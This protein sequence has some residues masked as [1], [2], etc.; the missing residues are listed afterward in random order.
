[1]AVK[2]GNKIRYKGVYRLY[3]N[4]VLASETPYNLTDAFGSTPA[5]TVEELQLMTAQD[6]EARAAAM[7]QAISGK[8]NDF[9]VINN[10]IY[11]SDD[12]SDEE[13]FMIGQIIDFAGIEGTWDTDKWLDCDGRTLNTADYPELY[14]VI[15]REW[16]DASLSNDKFQLP[17]LGGRIALG[18]DRSSAELPRNSTD[19]TAIDYNYGRVGNKGGFASVRLATRNMPK[20]NHELNIYNV[21]AEHGD[22]GHDYYPAQ[23]IQIAAPAG[24][25]KSWTGETKYEGGENAQSAI[26]HENRQPYAV[27]R[28]LIRYK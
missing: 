18:F 4:G 15:G 16:T 22:S 28:K 7:I 8:C 19:E 20:H 2:T 12:C 17:Y 26:R 13:E 21:N 10:V 1:M 9:E 14:G 24:T 3:R 5:I 25:D 23:Y 27:V 6:I 11:K